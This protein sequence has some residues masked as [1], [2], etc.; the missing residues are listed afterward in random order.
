MNPIRVKIHVTSDTLQIPVLKGLVGKDV[1]IV[2]SE[3]RAVAQTGQAQ[4]EKE[5]YPLR[6]TVLRYDDPFGPAVPDSDWEANN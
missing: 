5:R 4:S 3:T 6:G 2:I 1:E